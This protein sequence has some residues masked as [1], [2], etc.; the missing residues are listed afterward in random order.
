[1]EMI[2]EILHPIV[3]LVLMYTKI[4]M[5]V[6][7]VAAR[8]SKHRDNPEGLTD[9]PEEVTILKHSNKRSLTTPHIKNSSMD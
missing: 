7:M 6:V 1:M 8:Q 9:Y 4:R 2:A 3:D 5:M